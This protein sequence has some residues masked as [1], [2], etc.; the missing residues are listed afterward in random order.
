LSLGSYNIPKASSGVDQGHIVPVTINKSLLVPLKIDIDP[1]VQAVRNQEKEQIKGLN[2]RFATFIDKVRFL[3]QQNKMLETKWNLLQQQ[4]SAASA[5]DPMMKQYISNLQ[6]QLEFISNDKNRLNTENNV[7]HKTVDDY[8]K[9]YEQEINK[10]NDVE[11]DFVVLKKDVDSGYMGKMDIQDKVSGIT[12]QVNFLKALYDMELR[13]LQDSLKTTSVVVEM[14]NS[15]GLNMDQIVS[16]VKGQYEGIAARSRDEAE[17][18][19][20]KKFDQMS[21]EANQYG[22]DLRNSKGEIAELNRMINRLQNEIQTVKG[23]RTNLEGQLAEAEL[24]GNDA[25]K[26]ARVRIRDLEL[27][28]QRAK[29]DMARQVREYQ[30]LMNVKLA[31]DI[32]ISTYR[33]LLEGE[34]QRIGH[35]SILNIHTVPTKSV[36]VHTKQ[37]RRSG[38]V[39]IK[40]VETQDRSYI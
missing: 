9:K 22:D 18:W 30:E 17:S 4:T 34:E 19:Y 37:R 26:D 1:T 31:L 8:R 38:P 13:E 39:L 29:Q 24:R 33:K 5:V 3:E 28:L 27:A 12:D 36:Q 6:R 20:K 23:Q 16:E 40:T 11:N 25:V 21:G 35:D 15:R 10:R 2:N 14:D 7:M 32:E